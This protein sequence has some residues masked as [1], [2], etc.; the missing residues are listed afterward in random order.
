MGL[1]D[2]AEGG[3]SESAASLFC[4]KPCGAC[5]TAGAGGLGAEVCRHGFPSRNSAASNQQD[6]QRQPK[7]AQVPGAAPG[8]GAWL[9]WEGQTSWPGS[10]CSS[11]R[12]RGSC[13]SFE[14]LE[15]QVFREGPGAVAA[16][17]VRPRHPPASAAAAP[18]SGPAMAALSDHGA[19][20]LG[21]GVGRFQIAARPTADSAVGWPRQGPA[22]SNPAQLAAQTSRQFHQANCW[23]GDWHMQLRCRPH[24]SDGI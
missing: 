20:G 21:L 12:S 8:G 19:M 11:S 23:P 13:S 15:P 3:R 10:S 5:R 16:N 7:S 14:L 18:R 24:F 4:L 6:R 1:A 22:G 9:G 2:L 17:N